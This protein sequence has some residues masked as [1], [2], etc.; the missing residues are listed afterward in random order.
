MPCRRRWFVRRICRR[1]KLAPSALL[2]RSN[3]RKLWKN[4]QML[5]ALKAVEEGQPVNIAVCDHGIPK[6]TLKE[7]L[8]G[9][10]THGTNPGPKLYLNTVE[11]D[12]L[13]KVKS[14][15]PGS[16][17]SI[18]P[19]YK[20]LVLPTSSTPTGPK[21]LSHARL[22]TSAECLSQLEERNAKNS[23]PQKRKSR[24]KR[25]K[26]KAAPRSESSDETVPKKQR[27]TL[28]DGNF[29]AV[30][31]ASYGYRYV[32]WLIIGSLC[33]VFLLTLYICL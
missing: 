10:V 26:M 20:Y 19:I 15:A 13:G 9:R 11:E 23:W 2:G 22:L 28:S 29:W 7:R 4:E 17:K 27:T 8:S 1:S 24:E 18:S 16:G 6:T 25:N 12:K 31:G 30:P 5:A 32:T 21:T 14:C 33:Y 3:K